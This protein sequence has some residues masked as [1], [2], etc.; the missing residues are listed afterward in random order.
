MSPVFI[1][2]LLLSAVIGLSLGL[3]GGGGSILTVPILVYFLAVEPHEAVGM[4][5][6][7]VGATSLL[8]A[9]LHYR[10]GNVDISGGIRFGAFGMI[11]AVAGSPLTRSVSPTTLLLLFGLLMMTVA[12]AMLW[13]R[14]YKD[15]VIGQK[16]R[17][18]QGIAVGFG[19]GVLTGFLGVGGG[20]LIVPA[21]VLF[22]GLTMKKAIGTSLFVIFLNC[23]AG[24]IGHIGRDMFDWALTAAVLALAVGGAVGGT[25]LSNRL[26]AYRLQRIFAVLVL[27]VGAA[28][29]V[30]NYAVAF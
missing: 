25:A 10:R 3:I 13:R 5:L 30:K 28:L 1:I 15:K 17:I 26:A 21:L 6:A 24:L 18:L 19:V 2:G 29:V 12:I 9:Y 20:F 14:S 7:V 16:P 11:G 22:G 27:G 4:S 8:G 23:I